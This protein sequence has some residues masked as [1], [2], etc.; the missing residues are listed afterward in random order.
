MKYGVEVKNIF[1]SNRFC[2]ALNDKDGAFAISNKAIAE[3][4][5]LDESAYMKRVFKVIDYLDDIHNNN[6]LVV[7]TPKGKVTKELLLENFKEEFEK[8]LVLLN[9]GGE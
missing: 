5:N 4:L 2:F 6:G 9:L 3:K 8:E 1:Y 7:F